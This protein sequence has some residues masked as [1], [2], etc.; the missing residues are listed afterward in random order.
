MP[1]NPIIIKYVLCISEE[2][3]TKQL[4]I[5]ATNMEEHR[6]RINSLTDKNTTLKHDDENINREMRSIC[7]HTN[8]HIIFLIYHYITIKYAN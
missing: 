4:K 6:K 7:L 1:Y 3:L 2:N 8:M 5:I